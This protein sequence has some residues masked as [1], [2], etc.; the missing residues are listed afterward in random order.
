MGGVRCGGMGC[1]GVGCEGVRCEGMEKR[2]TTEPRTRDLRSNVEFQPRE[3]WN[4][5][6]SFVPHHCLRASHGCAESTTA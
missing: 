6:R 4:Q 1:E 5:P 3:L 2:P